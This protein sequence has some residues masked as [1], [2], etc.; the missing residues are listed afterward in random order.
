LYARIESEGEYVLPA[1]ARE[2]LKALGS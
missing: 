1:R 2:C